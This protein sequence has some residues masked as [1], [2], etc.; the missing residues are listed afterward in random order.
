MALGISAQSITLIIV[1]IFKAGFYQHDYTCCI[2]PT[3]SIKTRDMIYIIYV[4]VYVWSY[5]NTIN[6]QCIVDVLSSM[7]VL[8]FHRM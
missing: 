8:C 2:I 4:C 7:Y 6:I 1:Q 5:N 3:I